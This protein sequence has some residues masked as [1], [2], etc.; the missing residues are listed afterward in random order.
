LVFSRGGRSPTCWRSGGCRGGG[1]SARFWVF[2]FRRVSASRCS[3]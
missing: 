2:C 1:F 3:R